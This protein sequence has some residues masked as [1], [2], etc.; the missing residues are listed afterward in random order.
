MLHLILKSKKRSRHKAKAE[1]IFDKIAKEKILDSELTV[2][3]LLNLSK[4]L[5]EELQL[6]SNAQLIEEIENL[7]E[8]LL[9]IAVDQNNFALKAE[10]Y[11]LQAKVALLTL[12]L[13]KAREFLT[14][15][16]ITADGK[17]LERLAILISEDH[18][19]LLNQLA[20]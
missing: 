3:A 13:N 17:G 2:L 11:W 20:M 9:E 6:T 18:D 15:A 4:L 5:L 16:Q 12:E 7:L 1:E 10:T 8:Q 19:K 14:L